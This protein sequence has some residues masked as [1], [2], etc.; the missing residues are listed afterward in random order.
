MPVASPPL[1]AATPRLA[2]ATPAAPKPKKAAFEP[3]ISSADWSPPPLLSYATTPQALSLAMQQVTGVSGPRPGS[4]AQLYEQRRLALQSGQLY[5]R[6]APNT[7]QAQWSAAAA[8][9]TY[10]QWKALLAQEA[11]AIAAGQG[12]NRLSIVVG[13]SLSLWMPPE[14]LPRDR[15]WLNQGISGD[16][17]AGVLNRLSAFAS[18]RPDV[19]HVMAGVNDLK[20]GASDTTVLTNLNRIMQQLRQQHPQAR[21]VVHSILPTRLASIPSDRIRALNRQI[22]QTARTQGV[23]YLDLHPSFTDNV[24][25]LRYELTTDGLHLSRLGYQVWQIAMLAV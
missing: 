21:I 15:F 7:F 8:Q 16:T 11:N 4:G 20:N 9:P 12:S 22:A 18:A 17:T 23:V 25:D 3:A 1:A 2:A 5:T 24:G 13:D 19:I 6:L 14:L 10:E